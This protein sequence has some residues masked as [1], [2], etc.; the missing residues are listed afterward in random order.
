VKELIEYARLR[1]VRV[2]PEMDLPMHSSEL[3]P[4]EK[5]GV[6]YC[7]SAVKVA[8]YNDPANN[9]TARVITR[10]MS[11]MMQLFRDEVFHIGTDEVH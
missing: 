6:T 1:G 10:L 9:N 4:L 7:N 3:R 5:Y 2:V 8:L 11:E